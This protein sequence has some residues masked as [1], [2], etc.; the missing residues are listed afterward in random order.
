MH[1]FWPTGIRPHPLAPPSNVLMMVSLSR[2]LHSDYGRRLFVT[3]NKPLPHVVL[4]PY[5]REENYIGIDLDGQDVSVEAQ[6]VVGVMDSFLNDYPKTSDG[7]EDYSEL[8]PSMTVVSVL[9]AMANEKKYHILGYF[10][11]AGQT[12]KREREGRRKGL[13]ERNER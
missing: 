11:L 2:S 3:D 9:T 13:G 6:R 4:L 5:G 12:R 8:G 10:C 1:L 7:F